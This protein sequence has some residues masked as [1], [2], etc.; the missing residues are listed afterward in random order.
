[1]KT[2]EIVVSNTGETQ[3]VTTGFAGRDCLEATRLLEAALGRPTADRLTAEFYQV[4]SEP[5]AQRLSAGDQA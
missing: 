3:I 4:A 1:M 2:I 5:T